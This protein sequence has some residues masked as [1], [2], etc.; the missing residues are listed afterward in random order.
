MT[1]D[2]QRTSATIYQFPAGGRRGRGG[3]QPKPE[4]EVRMPDAVASALG[5]AWYHDAAIQDSAIQDSKRASEH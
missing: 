5:A 1:T 2:V 4:P 3:P